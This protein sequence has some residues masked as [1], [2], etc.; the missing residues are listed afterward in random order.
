MRRTSVVLVVA[1][2]ALA[3]TGR[4]LAA[5]TQ[6][7]QTTG[8]AQVVWFSHGVTRGLQQEAD[9][10]LVAGQPLALQQPAGKVYAAAYYPAART[11]ATVDEHA[12][13]RLYERAGDVLA[14]TQTRPPHEPDPRYRLGPIRP[15]S[16]RFSRIPGLVY[17]TWSYPEPRTPVQTGWQYSE[18][19]ALGTRARNWHAVTAD[20]SRVV[21]LEYTYR[22]LSSRFLE[23]FPPDGKRIVIRLPAPLGTVRD[24]T[25]P[26]L[27][28]EPV[29]V[30]PGRAIICKIRSGWS[31]H[32]RYG[33]LI[34]YFP[35]GRTDNWGW[36][37]TTYQNGHFYVFQAVKG[38]LFYQMDIRAGK[39]TYV[40]RSL[41]R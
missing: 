1:V 32:S 24:G 18:R 35:L 22:V 27:G 37:G 29:F 16:A 31:L 40:G 15:V 21:F 41:P 26:Y 14:L 20:D 38:F 39:L 33:Q 28:S 8:A 2:S 3:A 4:S 13:T 9:G 19:L 30:L 7:A 25:P 17:L 6:E 5:D 36:Y 23:L 10:R 12:V 11:L 34:R